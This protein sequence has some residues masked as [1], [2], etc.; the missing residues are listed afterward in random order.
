M[1]ILVGNNTLY[2]L[3]GSETHALTLALELKKQGHEVCAYSPIL[4]IIAKTLKNNG[5]ECFNAPPDK[6]FDLI[7]ASHHPIVSTLRLKYPKTPI[8]STIHGILHTQGS[9][10]LPEYPADGVN[11]F[12]A[13]SEE[14]Q[15]K[16][17]DDYGLDSVIIRNFFQIEANF[18][19]NKI[20]KKF[21]FNSNYNVKGD[22]VFKTV[23]EI[24]N[25]YHAE[26]LAIGNNF[27]ETPDVRTA[28]LQSD[29]VFGIGR[30]V[31]EGVALGRLGVV[32]GRWGTGGVV[33][34]KNIKNLQYYNFSGRNATRLWTPDETI[35]EIDEFYTQENLD[36]CHQYMLENHNVGKAVLEYL[37][38]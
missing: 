27:Y 35:K 26:L 37:S 18:P 24:A 32:H 25:Y 20:P 19:I 4:G 28:I 11:Q 5:V 38:L 15:K 36:W 3:A 30:S 31:L 33:C 14:V 16:L 8:I 7:I 22:Q 21:L 34:Q 9:A 6:E 12:V 29:I 13:V 17:K 23:E 10:K 1:K 2:Q